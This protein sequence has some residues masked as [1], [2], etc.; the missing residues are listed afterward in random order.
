MD[1]GDAKHRFGICWLV[2]GYTLALHVLDEA[3][4]NFLAV[5]LPNALV[6]RRAVPFLPMPLFTFES[7]IGS[8]TLGLT[9]WL[10]L[11]PFAFRGQKWTRV[12]AIPMAIVVGLLNG[13]AHL[14]ASIYMGRMMPGVYSAPLLLFSGTLLLRSALVQRELS[15]G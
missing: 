7:W 15:V 6:V 11:T 2:F 5:Y 4:N 10:A 9:V 8:L 13:T 3:G 12:L 14:V 1:L